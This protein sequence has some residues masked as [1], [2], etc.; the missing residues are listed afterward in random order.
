MEKN[1]R[2]EGSCGT[3]TAMEHET[4]RTRMEST[5]SGCATMHEFTL[6]FVELPIIQDVGSNSRQATEF[7]LFDTFDV[8]PVT[9]SIFLKNLG[10]IRRTRNI[11]PSFPD[12]FGG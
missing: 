6:T 5:V 4:I 1:L 10:K 9:V 2:G 11:Q 3:E 8:V 7:I 12:F